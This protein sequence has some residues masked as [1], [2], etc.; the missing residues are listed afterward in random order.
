MRAAE[1]GHSNTFS[2]LLDRGA[3]IEAKDEV[4]ELGYHYFFNLL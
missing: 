1:K 2:L 4:S 3:N